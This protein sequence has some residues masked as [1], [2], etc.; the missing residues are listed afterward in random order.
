MLLYSEGKLCHVCRLLS[1]GVA[2]FIGCHE[3]KRR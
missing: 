2:S 3:Q 1:R